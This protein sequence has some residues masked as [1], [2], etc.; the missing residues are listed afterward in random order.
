MIL[1]DFSL[2]NL[3]D[4]QENKL[5]SIF[6]YYYKYKELRNSYKNFKEDGE[7]DYATIQ[8]DAAHIYEWR[9][10]DSCQEFGLKIEFSE[11]DNDPIELY[12]EAIE[13]YLESKKL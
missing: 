12:L 11:K 5:Y 13:K 7:E 6:N 3:T 10:R 4:E 9:F 2:F 1:K 8:F